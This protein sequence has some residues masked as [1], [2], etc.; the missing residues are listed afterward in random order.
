MRSGQPRAG[1]S[2]DELRKNERK[3]MN[4][5]IGGGFLGP[6]QSQYVDVG[7]SAG[8]N[9]R[10]YAHPEDQTVDF[11]LGIYDENG[12]SVAWDETYDADAYGVVQPIIFTGPFR[13]V[14]KSARGSSRYAVGIYE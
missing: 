2:S 9:Y 4:V 3:L 13:V 10:I 11:D 5:L 6:G 14:V 8:H 1:D 7:L 12:N